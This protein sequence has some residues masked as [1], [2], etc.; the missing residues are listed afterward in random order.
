MA[1]RTAY[2]SVVI[3][4]GFGSWV[5]ASALAASLASVVAC[6]AAATDDAAPGGS[7]D[8]GNGSGGGTGGGTPAKV[9]EGWTIIPL[10]DQVSPTDPKDTVLR[11]DDTVTGINF[12]SADKGL[13]VTQE[14]HGSNGAGGVVFH[15]TSS[16]VTS[17]AFS[18]VDQQASDYVGIVPTANGYIALTDAY[19]FISSSDGGAT[20]THALTGMAR[21]HTNGTFGLEHALAYQVSPTGTT[22]AT[23]T[24]V[25]AVSIDASAP[26]ATTYEDVWAPT[27]IPPIPD[28]LE[29]GECEFGPATT[30]L[31]AV[32][33]SVRV[34][35]DRSFIVYTS[36]DDNFHPQICISTDGGHSVFA[37]NLDVADD[38]TGFSPTGVL[39][40]DRMHG[41]TW[42]GNQLA[43]PYVQRTTDGGAT[44][45]NVALPA[46]VAT[47]N[48]ELPVGFFAPDGLHGWLAGFDYGVSRAV[49]ITTA[50]GGETWTTVSGVGAAVDAAGGSKLYAGFALDEKHVWFGGVDGALIHN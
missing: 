1:M 26:T 19:E 7:P 44:W 34:S 39:F 20:F 48:V 6:S 25:I 8:P 16:A 24:G 43:T 36:N 47:S 37:T 31:P 21:D 42:F 40:T 14:G 50:D 9:V 29:P 18:D 30:G 5:Q 12:Q 46:A 32:N 11:T 38:L 3:G 10:I 41:I 13:I 33:N 17:V 22:I 28:V 49:A 2:R 15:A 35:E 4:S 27:G 23:D 45:H